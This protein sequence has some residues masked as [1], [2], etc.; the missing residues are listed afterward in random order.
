M[1]GFTEDEK[2]LI[3]MVLDT[4]KLWWNAVPG[5]IPE[6]THRDKLIELI[7]VAKEESEK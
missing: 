1:A 7:G 5:S 6:R 2:V 4:I 3:G